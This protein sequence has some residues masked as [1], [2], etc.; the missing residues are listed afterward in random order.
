MF[1][2][3]TKQLQEKSFYFCDNPRIYVWVDADV[4]VLRKNLDTYI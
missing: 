3:K 1:V 2:R 4:K